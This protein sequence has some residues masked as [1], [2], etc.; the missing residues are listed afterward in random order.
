MFSDRVQKMS[1]W[2]IKS[3]RYLVLTAKNVYEFRKKS[4]ESL[5]TPPA[6]EKKQGIH[7]VR[8]I[9]KSTVNKAEFVLHF[10]HHHDWRFLADRREDFLNILK[11]RFACLVH[12][13]TLKVYSVVNIYLCE[14]QHYPNLREFYTSTKNKKH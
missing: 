6:L 7:D 4:K 14:T 3:E 13:L 12:S 1:R 8:A 9:I 10:P 11:L 5:F 2:N